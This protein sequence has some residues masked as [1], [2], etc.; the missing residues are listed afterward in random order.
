[1]RSRPHSTKLGKADPRQMST[2]V[3]RLCGQDSMG[4]SGVSAQSWVRIRS[5]IPPLPIG[6]GVFFWGAART[7]SS[8]YRAQT[9]GR[10]RLAEHVGRER[11]PL[12]EAVYAGRLDQGP[13]C[14]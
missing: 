1:M 8:P 7:I 9:N 11:A 2:T 13:A 6:Q 3:R 14:D 10:G 4:P 5:T 12:A